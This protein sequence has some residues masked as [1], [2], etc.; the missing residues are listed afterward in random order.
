MRLA[1]TPPEEEEASMPIQPSQTESRPGKG[2]TPEPSNHCAICR[3]KGGCP[4]CID[5]ALKGYGLTGFRS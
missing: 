2:R 1:A 3:N 4:T 5:D